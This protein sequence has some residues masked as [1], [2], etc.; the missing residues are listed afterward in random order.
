MDRRS[1]SKLLGFGIIGCAYPAVAAGTAI[2]A[3]D[4]LK[5]VKEIKGS[6]TF[7][8]FP[9]KFNNV[10]EAVKQLQKLHG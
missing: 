5:Q 1:F 9:E 3:K 8:S 4:K 6:D 7:S 2:L 10:V